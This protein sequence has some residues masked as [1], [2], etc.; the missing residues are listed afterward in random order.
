MVDINHTYN[1]GTTCQLQE[2]CPII[3]QVDCQAVSGAN[4]IR[5]N[6]SWDAT[7]GLCATPVANNNNVTNVD[8]NQINS[9]LGSANSFVEST[10]QTNSLTAEQHAQLHGGTDSFSNNNQRPVQPF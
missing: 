6:C 7:L 5:P 2:G 9:L 8:W 3:Q 10:S 4:G 1:D